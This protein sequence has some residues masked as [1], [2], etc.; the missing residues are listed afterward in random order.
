M[1]FCGSPDHR[2]QVVCTEAPKW[3]VARPR[4]H[5]RISV[6]ADV[7]LVLVS[8]PAGFGKTTLLVEWLEKLSRDGAR[9]AWISLDPSDNDPLMFWS[10][11]IGALDTVASLGSPLREVL[12]VT[13]FFTDLMVTALVNELVVSTEELWL[14]LDDFHAVDNRDIVQ[15]LSV[16]LDRLPSHVHL[17]ISTR[18][19]PA[20]PLSRSRVRGELVEIRAADL[21]FTPDEAAVYLNEVA[22]LGFAKSDVAVLEKRTEGWVA[23]LQLAALSMPGQD[24]VRG[25]ISRFA[26]ND[27]YIVDYLVEEVLQRQPTD[28]RDFLSQ[29]SVLDRLSGSL[30]D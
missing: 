5:E 23:A 20:L 25:F 22:E 17:V 7:R 14:L 10:C 24:D 16:L 18:V 6:L 21:R 15:G 27:R 29:S 8:A 12:D 30:C 26:G 1:G 28:V 19:D 2:Y 4:L 11:V 3:S 13:P 9:V